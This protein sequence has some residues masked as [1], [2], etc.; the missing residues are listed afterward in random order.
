M[1][2]MIFMF[3]AFLKEP[4]WFKTLISITLLVSIVFSSSIISYDRI[5]ESISKFAAAIFFCIYGFKL[6]KNLRTSI[7]FL[8]L[9]LC[10]FI[11]LYIISLRLLPL[12]SSIKNSGFCAKEYI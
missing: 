11:F 12:P 4:L 10:V 6:R 8:Y 1:Q 5:Y 9:Q 7:I 3:R 2:R